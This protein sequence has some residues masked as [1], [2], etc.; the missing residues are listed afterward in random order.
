VISEEQLCAVWC[1]WPAGT[2]AV[3]L[4]L[5]T[6]VF[7]RRKRLQFCAQQESGGLVFCLF[8]HCT[9]VHFGLFFSLNLMVRNSPARSRFFFVDDWVRGFL[10]YLF[11][12]S[13]S[14]FPRWLHCYRFC[15]G[16]FIC[17]SLYQH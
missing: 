4:L 17:G 10:G 16:W 12:T 14:I 2:F 8:W 15:D 7:M 3:C 1:V 11:S 6:A 9:L 5:R 13:T